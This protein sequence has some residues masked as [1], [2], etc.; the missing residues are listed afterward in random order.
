VLGQC[1][2]TRLPWRSRTSA[3]NLL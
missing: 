2:V 3:K 1:T